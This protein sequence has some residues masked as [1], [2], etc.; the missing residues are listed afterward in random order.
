MSKLSIKVFAFPAALALL[1]GGMLLLGPVRDAAAATVT[2]DGIRTGDSRIAFDGLRFV[3]IDENPSSE[4]D[5]EST[6][7]VEVGTPPTFF[8]FQF[9][10]LDGLGQP[11]NTVFDLTV[12]GGSLTF[13]VFLGQPSFAQLED[14]NAGTIGIGDLG[15]T[16]LF[17]SGAL[18]TPLNAV[19]PTTL[20]LALS[21]PSSALISVFLSGEATYGLTI[22]VVNA[23]PLPVPA[24]LL[25]SALL[26]LGFLGRRNRFGG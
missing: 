13:D 17:T 25:I 20:N 14:L 8:G 19:E 4:L 11:Q 1:V 3:A 16:S 12:F 24:L 18:T 26:G 6:G 2:V 10:D 5:P 23:V 7:P 15:L 22:D 9:F 21:I